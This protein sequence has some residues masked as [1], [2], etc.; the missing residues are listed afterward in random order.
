[1]QKG[2]RFEKKTDFFSSLQLKMHILG[3]ENAK[4]IYFLN[5][6]EKG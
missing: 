2:F 1:M 4:F 6:V 5:Q 3:D